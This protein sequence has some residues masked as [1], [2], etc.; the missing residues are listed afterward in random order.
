MAVNFNDVRPVAQGQWLSILAHVAPALA[1][2]I[3]RHPRHVAC[4]VHGGKDGFRLYKNADDTGG[5]ICNTCGAF[6]D[7]FA[8]ICWCNGWQLPDALKAVADYL[9]IA[10]NT[11]VKAITPSAKQAH[12]PKQIEREQQRKREALEG[13]KKGLIPLSDEGAAPARRYIENRGLVLF[14][15]ENLCPRDLYFHP[16]LHYWH[17]GKDYGNLPALVAI[18]RSVYGK[19]I[20]LHRT[21]LTESG[22]KAAVPEVK[23]LMSPVIPGTTR[24]AAIQL[25][26]AENELI[27]AEGIETALALHLSLNKPCWACISA[28]G[29]EAV[30]LP[31]QVKRVIIGADN[32]KSGAGQKAAYELANRLIKEVRGIQVKIIIPEHIGTDWLDVFNGEDKAA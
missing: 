29:L 23:K 7:G 26:P 14:Q 3:E 18:V 21:Y 28:G 16:A 1:E 13:V 2:A 10:E 15:G 12:D 4:P 32:D 20:T 22:Q 27:L 31:E 5:G 17:D 6:S 30:Q 25:Y 11:D 19:P 9:G 8:L 24:G